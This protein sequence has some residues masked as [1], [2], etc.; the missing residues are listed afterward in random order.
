MK[1]LRLTKNLKNKIKFQVLKFLKGFFWKVLKILT[2]WKI[3][4]LVMDNPEKTVNFFHCK[5][6][7]KTSKEANWVLEV[8]DFQ[9]FSTLNNIH[10]LHTPTTITAALFYS[11]TGS[12]MNNFVTQLKEAR[13]KKKASNFRPADFLPPRTMSSWI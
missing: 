13:K 1:V 3:K 8:V 5:I 10:S 11:M 6:P 9:V 12:L 2:L 7:A 4:F